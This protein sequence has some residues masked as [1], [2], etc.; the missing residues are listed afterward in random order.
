MSAVGLVDSS[1]TGVPPSC[2]R[3]S[4]SDGAEWPC[5]HSAEQAWNQED[6]LPLWNS[7][8]PI[9]DFTG[10]R[11]AVRKVQESE[12]LLDDDDCK[13]PDASYDPLCYIWCKYI[14]ILS[15]SLL[16]LLSA[17]VDLLC[18]RVQHHRRRQAVKSN[19]T[20]IHTVHDFCQ[21]P[22]GIRYQSCTIKDWN[23]VYESFMKD[24]LKE[25]D[26]MLKLNVKFL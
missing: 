12:N 21:N 23:I 2:E 24:G 25:C 6:Q 17:G 4:V 1:F 8:N 3:L 16:R 5:V 10:I 22:N 13:Q 15:L 11:T 9:E 20:G 26:Q 14:Y 19:P 18:L 7:A